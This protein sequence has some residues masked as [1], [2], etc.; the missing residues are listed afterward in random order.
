MLSMLRVKLVPNHSIVKLSNHNR[1]SRGD[2]EHN[3]VTVV[4]N[5]LGLGIQAAFDWI[6]LLYDEMG[7]RFMT[8]YMELCRG[9]NNEPGLDKQIRYADALGNWVRAN[10]QWSFEVCLKL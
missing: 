5:E 2:D 4:M 3:L 1:Q 7:H 6:E 10:D 9:Q 8:K